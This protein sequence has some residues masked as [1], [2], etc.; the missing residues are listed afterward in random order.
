M[1]KYFVA[2]VGILVVLVTG[3]VCQDLFWEMSA[4]GLI[5]LHFSF[6]AAAGQEPRNWPGLYF[7]NQTDC[8]DPLSVGQLPE[9]PVSVPMKHLHVQSYIQETDPDQLLSY[10]IVDFHLQHWDHFDY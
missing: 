5:L 6:V 2:V 4:G 3:R 10:S 8:L 1:T 9:K 7:P